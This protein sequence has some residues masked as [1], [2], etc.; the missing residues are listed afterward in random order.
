M[1]RSKQLKFDGKRDTAGKKAD[2]R[3]QRRMGR[4][5][6]LILLL[7]TTLISLALYLKQKIAG[8]FGLQE[9]GGV[10]RITFE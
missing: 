7:I 2:K 5:G 10:E 4:W 8:G 9:V 6:I 1:A 3:G